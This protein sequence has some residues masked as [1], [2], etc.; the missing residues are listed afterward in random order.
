MN[1]K[2][3]ISC[4]PRHLFFDER[5]KV[6]GNEFVVK[7]FV[8]NLYERSGLVSDNFLVCVDYWVWRYRGIKESP[9]A[10]SLSQ[11]K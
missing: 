7:L 8:K 11:L 5:C 2:S 1:D 9:A 4:N 10:S 3:P 6:V